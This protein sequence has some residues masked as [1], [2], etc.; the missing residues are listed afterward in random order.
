MNLDVETGGYLMQ[1]ES[2]TK[3]FS[4]SFLQYYRD[5]TTC[6]KINNMC[7]SVVQFPKRLCS[8]VLFFLCLGACEENIAKIDKY[9]ADIVFLSRS[10]Y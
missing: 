3:S 2:V 8:T 10:I 9:L 1:P 6:P 4:M 5:A 7:F